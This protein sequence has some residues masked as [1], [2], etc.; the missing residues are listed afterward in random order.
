VF[1]Q[2]PQTTSEK[3]SVIAEQA[4]QNGEGPVGKALESILAAADQIAKS[5]GQELT[6]TAWATSLTNAEFITLRLLLAK[7]PHSF[8]VLER[9]GQG[10]LTSSTYRIVW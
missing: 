3:L 9:Q 8:Q 7:E 1:K 6:L 10:E 4:R 2:K 5:G